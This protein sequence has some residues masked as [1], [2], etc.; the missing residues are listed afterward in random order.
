MNAEWTLDPEGHRGEMTCPTSECLSV[1]ADFT[2]SLRCSPSAF[3]LCA[4]LMSQDNT[5]S[6]KL[7][8]GPGGGGVSADPGVS[9]VGS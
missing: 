2:L 6:V 4:C 9:P 5:C 8:W 1:R 3:P 7:C